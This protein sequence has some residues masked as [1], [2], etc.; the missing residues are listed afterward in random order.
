MDRYQVENAV[1]KV[2]GY[3]IPRTME[4]PEA[5]FQR[6]RTDCL[7]ELRKEIAFLEQLTHEQFKNQRR[8]WNR[9]P[10]APT[11]SSETQPDQS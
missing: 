5:T 1:Y 3:Y 6:A 4:A 11:D 2:D 9:H 7:N 10:A 8:T